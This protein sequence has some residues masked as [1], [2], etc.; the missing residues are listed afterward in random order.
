LSDNC[1]IFDEVQFR[2]RRRSVF[3]SVAWLHRCWVWIFH[4]P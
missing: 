2:P 4:S 1:R 3:R